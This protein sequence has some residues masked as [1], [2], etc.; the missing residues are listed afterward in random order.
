MILRHL[1]LEDFRQFRDDTLKFAYGN[2]GVTVVHGANGSGKTTLLNAFTWVLYGEVDFD[3]RPDRLASEGAMAEAEPG[4]TV[5]VAVELDFTHDGEEYHARRHRRYEKRGSADFDG[6]TVDEGIEVVRGDSDDPVGNP[7]DTLDRVVP[8]RLSELFFFD[9][10]DIDEL[11]GIDNQ[12]QIQESIENLMGLTILERAVRHLGT[13][14][15]RFKSEVDEFASDELCDVSEEMDEVIERIERLRAAKQNTEQERKQVERKARDIEESLSSRERAK[16]LHDQRKTHEEER[17]ALEAE[18]ESIDED[19]RGVVDDEATEA[20]AVPLVRETAEQLDEMREEGSI[21]SGVDSQFVESLIEDGA[22]V[23]GRP[24]EPG[25]D[26]HK[27]LQKIKRTAVADGVEEVA[28][29][30]VG[31]IEQFSEADESFEERVADLYDTREQ[32]QDELQWREEKVEEIGSELSEMDSDVEGKSTI[33]EL[34]SKREERQQKARE[35]SRE[36]GQYENEIETKEERLETLEETFDELNDEREEALLAKRRRRAT[37]EVREDLQTTYDRLKDKVRESCNDL[38]G[39]TFDDVASK[40]LT[41]EVDDDFRLRITQSVGG[42]TV[43]VDKSTGERQI[44]SLAFVG[45]LVKLARI[46]YESDSQTPYF[47]GGIYP[48]VMDSPFGALDKSHRR[49]VSR[50]IPEMGNQVVVFATDSQWDG[51]VEEEMSNYVGRQYWLDFD[52]GEEDESYPKT[53]V[54]AEQM[55]VGGE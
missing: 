30:I 17:D 5:E 43:E 45:S 15:G 46:R 8:E 48:L 39:Q 28:M 12:D 18:I 29:R 14:A 27:H 20:L 47:S 41:A 37:K 21:P 9:G 42:Q 51:P 1:R 35:L 52:P 6:E 22:C 16:A 25:T 40:S 36:I 24:I 10:E 19:L 55:A 33:A 4:E 44:A 11:A 53:R 3:T 13:V 2:D 26:H 34:E 54:L 50:V 38:I 23:C 49:E 32:K 31:H 7:E